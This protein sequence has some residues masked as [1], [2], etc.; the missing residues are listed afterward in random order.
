VL[1]QHFAKSGGLE[2]LFDSSAHFLA[3]SRIFAFGQR[4]EIL[5][6]GQGHARKQFFRTGQ[7]VDNCEALCLYRVGNFRQKYFSA[8]DGIDGTIGLF[9]GNSAEQKTI[10]IPFR[11]IPQRKKGLEFCFVE[12]TFK[13]ILGI[14]F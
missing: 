6:Q 4:L 3:E 14:P 10:G 7:Q 8:E 1:R 11:T 5:V 13:P 12:L 2:N 9:R